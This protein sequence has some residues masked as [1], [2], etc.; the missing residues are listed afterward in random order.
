MRTD[1]VAKLNGPSGTVA[2]NNDITIDCTESFDPD[3]PYKTPLLYSLECT[4][5]FDNSA[6]SYV[7]KES[8]KGLWVL[9]GYSIDTDT[10]LKYTCN[11]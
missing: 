7:I 4:K 6:C 11:V 2:D 1:L 10:A 3:D 8:S 5:L 9:H